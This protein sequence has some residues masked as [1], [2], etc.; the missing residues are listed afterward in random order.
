VEAVPG[1]PSTPLVGREVRSYR[2]SCCSLLGAGG[3]PG[4]AAFR[5]SATLQQPAINRRVVGSNPTRGAWKT[6]K[7]LVGSTSWRT[8][9]GLS[10]SVPATIL[11]A[12]SRN[13]TTPPEVTFRSPTRMARGTSFGPSHTRHV[14]PQWHAKDRSSV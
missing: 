9:L 2:L 5:Y 8:V 3:A 14:A 4:S 1:Q 11:F 7:L 13:T 10:T 12:V 6:S